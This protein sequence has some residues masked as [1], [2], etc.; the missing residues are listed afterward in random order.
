MSGGHASGPRTARGRASERAGRRAETLATLRLRL[1]GWRILARRLQTPVGEID[2]LARRGRMLAV[3]EV[4]RRP[5]RATAGEAV[6]PAQRRRLARAADW[7]LA[8]GETLGAG[9]IDGLRFDLIWVDRLGLP[10]HLPDAWRP[11]GP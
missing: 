9:G 8:R 4:K 2:I 10:H 6:L 11:D 3:V 7:V 1:T 5:D